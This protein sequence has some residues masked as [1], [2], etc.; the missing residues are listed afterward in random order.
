MRSIDWYFDFISPYAY[1]QCTQLHRLPADVG[2]NFQPILFAGL[3]N[4][5]GTLGPA[6]IGPKRHFIYRQ[7]LWYAKRHGIEFRMPPAHPFNPLAVLRLAIAL[8]RDPEA[9]KAIFHFIWAEGRNPQEPEELRSLAARLGIDDIEAYTA[10]ESLKPALR[11]ATAKAAAIGV[12]GVP[13][14][15]V[16][17]Q[18]FWGNDSTQM[19]IDYLGSPQD[20]ESAEMRALDDLPQAARRNT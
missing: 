4:H 14:A 12:F 9:I 3:L 5:W 6:E 20:F 18:L 10:N 2:V 7:V 16:D 13:T 17:Q 19:L 8:D 1:L 11:E 15:V